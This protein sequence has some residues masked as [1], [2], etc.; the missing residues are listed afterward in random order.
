[1]TS[2]SFALICAHSD[3]AWCEALG[4]VREAKVD[5]FHDRACMLS[6]QLS[7]SGGKYSDVLVPRLR[8]DNA[9]FARCRGMCEDVRAEIG[10][11]TDDRILEIDL[12][13]LRVGEAAL[14]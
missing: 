3:A 2:Y 13:T 12:A 8:C 11:Q 9:V 14:I 5:N 10:G 1:M 6:I 7:S 4:N